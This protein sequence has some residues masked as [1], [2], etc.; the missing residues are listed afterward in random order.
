MDE[1][2]IKKWSAMGNADWDKAEIQRLARESGKPLEVRC[3]EAFI[4][5][6]WTVRIGTYYR[7][8]YGELR[9]LD[10]WAERI[11]GF[12]TTGQH[13]TIQWTVPVRVLGSCKGFPKNTSPVSYSIS[14]QSLA[15]EQPLFMCYS[16]GIHGSNVTHHLQKIT[17]E[18]LLTK[19]NTSSRQVVGFDIFHREEDKKKNSKVPA[20]YSRKGDRDLYKEGLDS[21]IQATIFYSNEDKRK[22]LYLDAHKGFIALNLPLLVFSLPFWDI[23]IDTGDAGEPTLRSAGYHVTVHPSEPP[24]ANPRPPEPLAAILYDVANITYLTEQLDELVG[25]FRGKL[26]SILHGGI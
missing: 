20:K 21:S 13:G 8:T 16:C 11:L 9:E 1:E 10:F 6:K 18:W 19:L 5:A 23:P 12:E 22:P 4:K 25:K 3:A 24:P 26:Y 2:Q 17:A 15:I 14:S 7:D